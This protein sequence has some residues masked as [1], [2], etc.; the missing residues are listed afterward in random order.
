MTNPIK[1][2]AL[3]GLILLLVFVVLGLIAFT[4][5]LSPYYIPVFPLLLAF[6]YL[7]SVISFSIIVNATRRNPRDFTNKFILF[8]GIKL[9]IY[10]VIIILYLFFARENA[11]PFLIGF[12]ILYTVFS[13]YDVVS[14]VSFIRKHSKSEDPYKRARKK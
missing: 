10:L 3:R 2:F 14:S 9:I 12:F 7:V 13:I 1:Q 6:F 11:V 4:S 8:S 5:F